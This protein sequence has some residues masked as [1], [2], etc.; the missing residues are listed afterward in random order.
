MHDIAISCV[1]CIIHA[2]TYERQTP[3]AFR[4]D[5]AAQ[6]GYERARRILVLSP[7]VGANQRDRADEALQNLIDAHGPVVRGYPTWH[8][9]VP[10][11][12]PQI[13]VTDPSD[14]CG[15]QGLDHTIYFAHAFVSCPYDDG[16][17]IIES[18]DAMEPHPCATITAER[19]DVP[20]YNS[21]TTPILVRCDWH[22]TFLERHMVPKK[23][24]VPL[25]IQQ[26][27][28]MWHRAD[29]GE[30]WDTMRP[31]LLGDPHGSRSSLFVNQETAMAMKRVY[32]A[33]VESGMFG[34]LRMD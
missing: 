29:V 5:E 1:I 28:R 21:G 33:M 24:A 11:D 32:T 20:F 13:P 34:P 19:L 4:A 3:M 16:S 25:M 23:L 31:Y 30:R 27:M 18:V 7:G 14:R 15:Y 10:Q 2:N 22:E 26:E 6:D 8:P 9:L 12:N 17:R